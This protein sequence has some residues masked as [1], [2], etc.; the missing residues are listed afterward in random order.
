ML[1]IRFHSELISHTENLLYTA[2]GECYMRKLSDHSW[3][4]STPG[5]RDWGTL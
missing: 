5:V 2:Y 1:P 3:V 4:H